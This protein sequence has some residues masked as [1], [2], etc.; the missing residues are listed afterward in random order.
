MGFLLQVCFDDLYLGESLCFIIFLLEK[1]NL[2]TLGNYL[3]CIL[4]NAILSKHEER[5]NEKKID[6]IYPFFSK[7]KKMKF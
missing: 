7:H 4:E 5:I 2:E 1:I 6:G 3:T